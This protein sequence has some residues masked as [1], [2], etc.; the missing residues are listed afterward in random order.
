MDN[1]ATAQFCKH[2]DADEPAALNITLASG[3]GRGGHQLDVAHHVAPLVA[4][5][6]DV[7]EARRTGVG[8]HV[9]RIGAAGRHGVVCVFGGTRH[10][11]PRAW[12]S[13]R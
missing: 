4:K 12:N 10:V 7:V 13:H 9:D 1:G 6:V 5:V 3:T 11:V 2:P 8:N